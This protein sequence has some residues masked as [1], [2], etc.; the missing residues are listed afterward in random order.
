MLSH[1]WLQRS[2]PQNY[3][4][5]IFSYI[6]KNRSTLYWGKDSMKTKMNSKSLRRSTSQKSLK[7]I[8]GKTRSKRTKPRNKVDVLTFAWS[9]EVLPIWGTSGTA[10]EYS[11]NSW[12]AKET[13]NSHDVHIFYR[14]IRDIKNTFP[15]QNVFDWHLASKRD[16]NAIFSFRFKFD[17]FTAFLFGLEPIFNHIKLTLIW[18][19]VE[20]D[21]IIV[22]LQISA[23]SFSSIYLHWIEVTESFVKK[24]ALVEFFVWRGQNSRPIEV[25]FTHY[26]GQSWIFT[27][28]WRFSFQRFTDTF[29]L[30][31]FLL[32]LVAS[33]LKKLSIFLFTLMTNL[34]KGSKSFTF[35]KFMGMIM[36]HFII[37]K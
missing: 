26:Q 4:M 13:G 25:T 37:K 20:F 11:F 35:L 8:F 15:S 12:T 22:V 19:R 9:I 32:L 34:K 2:I 5:Y 3:K 24:Y 7:I 29:P 23:L 27:T 17:S 6:G 30:Q 10:R 36:I 33:F 31:I 1:G 16:A 21:K 28:A 18:L 14:K